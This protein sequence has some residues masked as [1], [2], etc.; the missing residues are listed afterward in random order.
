MRLTLNLDFKTKKK[1]NIGQQKLDTPGHSKACATTIKNASMFVI[2]FQTSNQFLFSMK[3]VLLFLVFASSLISAQSEDQHDKKFWACLQR[4][5]LA[6]KAS[7][8]NCLT[9]WNTCYNFV[10]SL[11][12]KEDR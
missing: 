1:Q 11:L 4:E 10:V 9:R 12:P 5:H 7:F 2:I 3:S 6:Q 8:F